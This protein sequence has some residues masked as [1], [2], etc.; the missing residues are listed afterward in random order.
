MKEKSRERGRGQFP[1]AMSY[2]GDVGATNARFAALI[3]GRLGPVRTLEVAKFPS[4]IEAAALILKDLEGLAGLQGAVLAVAGPVSTGRCVLTNCSWVIDAQDFYDA[5]RVKARIVNDFEAVAYSLPVLSPTDVVKIGGGGALPGAPS[6]VLGPGSGLG[7]ACLIPG[8]GTPLVLPSE[9][10][11]ATFAGS[12]E[13]EDAIIK[14]LRGMFGHVSAERVVSGDG[15]ENIYNAIVAL[16][17]LKSPPQSAAAITESALKGD[18]AATVEA[19]ATFC[20]FLGS[21]AGNTVLTF[22]A[23]GG[24]YIAGGIS[25]RIVDF[26]LKSEFRERFEAKGRFRDFLC[27]ISVQIIVHQAAA[28]LGLRTIANF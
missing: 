27:P 1:E 28:F 11:H 6:V 22:G 13:R 3:E 17:A 20:G 18:C 9:G 25:P 2:S 10:G 8:A 14:H 24:A 7:V 12:N 15:L 19:L 16:D 26:I 21:F 23:R 4:F 5:F